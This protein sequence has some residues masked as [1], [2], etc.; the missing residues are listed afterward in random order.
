MDWY[1]GQR[2]AI[3]KSR[4]WT[5]QDYEDWEEQVDTDSFASRYAGRRDYHERESDW[6]I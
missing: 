3:L 6:D 2:K 5:L 1:G 4:E